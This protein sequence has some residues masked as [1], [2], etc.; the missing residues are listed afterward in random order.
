MGGG[1][2]IL[3]LGSIVLISILTMAIGQMYVQSV[4]NTVE[5]QQ[6]S[7]ALNL[8]R[9]LSEDI[10]SYSFKA[11]GESQLIADYG[12]WNDVTEPGRRMERHSPAG[13]IFYATFEI[14]EVKDIVAEIGSN[15]QIEQSGRTVDVSIFEKEH[16]EYKRAVT[17]TTAFIPMVEDE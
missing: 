9:E 8:G 5:A 15:G 11:N 7:D 2:T 1:Q 12:S 17:F 10:Q 16:N 13:K 14:S 3:T 6:T 4:Y